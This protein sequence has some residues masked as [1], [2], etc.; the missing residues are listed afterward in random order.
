MNSLLRFYLGTSDPFAVVTRIAAAPGEKPQVLGKTEVI[1]NSLSPQWTK[2]FKFDYELGSPVRLAISVFDEVRKGENKTMGSAVFDVGE[3]LGARGNTKARKVKGGGTL[4]A[5]VRKSTGSGLLR[6]KM[7][8]LKLKNVEG[9]LGKSD[10]FFELSRQINA[11]GAA[12]WDNV[13]RS[14]PVKNNLSPTWDDAIVELSTLCGGDMNLPI[15]VSIFDH[16]SSGKHVSM[17]Q[18]ET[19]VK[20]LIEASTGGSED[21]GKALTVTKKGKACGKVIVLKA[22]VSGVESVTK[23]LSKAS[24][25][26][27]PSSPREALSGPSFV[28]YI[29]GGCELNVVVAIDFTGSNGDPRKPGTLH[30][31][32]PNSKNQ[33]EKAI[34][35]IVEIL[36]KYD[37]DQN[38]PV[39]GFGAK[40][41]GIVR[42]CFQCGPLEEVNGV[43]GVL[44]AYHQVFKSGLIMSSPTVF[45]E[46]IQ[47]AAARAQSSLEASLKEGKQSYT[48]L[49][50][51]SGTPRMNSYAMLSLLLGFLTNTLSF[52]IQTEQS[53]TYRR[54]PHA[55]TRSATAHCQW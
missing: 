34:S 43:N 21:E 8:A 37:S 11:A 49:L 17:G 31:L 18:F 44:E 26:P 27:A 25:S 19:T 55:W 15:L 30:H 35:A 13:Y 20:G 51:L 33:Y 24:I 46:V 50:I 10:P 14:A 5:H 36:A 41:N 39:M 48:I 28:D 29:S 23:E 22:Q 3:I 12:T 7:K 4:F 54:P 38:F 16:E 42:H 32:D 2:V 52:I 53:P 47:T 6:L 45:T 9:F 40:Y 1:K